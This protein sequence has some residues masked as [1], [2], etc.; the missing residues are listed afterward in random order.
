MSSGATQAVAPSSGLDGCRRRQRAA[1]AAPN[2][3]ALTINTIISHPGKLDVLAVETA[4]RESFT[5]GRAGAGMVSNARPG[6]VSRF[7]ASCLATPAGKAPPSVGS[8][9]PGVC[10]PALDGMVS[11]YWLNA[12]S[13]GLA[14]PGTVAAVADSGAMALNARTAT[15]MRRILGM[16]DLS[17]GRC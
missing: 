2:V 1:A 7:A 3:S 9:G 5:P 10:P 15:A 14:Q 6:P 16:S 4:A 12:L 8:P 13:V 11:Q 17:G